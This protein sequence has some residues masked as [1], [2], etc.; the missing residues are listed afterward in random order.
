M[1]LNGNF[2]YT[3]R[4]RVLHRLCPIPASYGPVF[5]AQH[6]FLL[7]SQWQSPEELE[8]YRAQQLN[9][10]VTHC[11]ENVPYYRSLFE[12]RGLKPKDFL[13]VADLGQLPLLS[14]ETVRDNVERLVATNI[15][16]RDREFCTTGGTTGAPLGLWIEKRAGSLRLAFDWRFYGWAGFRF[17][18][19]HAFLRGRSISRLPAG[20]CWKFDPYQNCLFFSSFNLNEANMTL[21]LRKMREFKP[22]VLHRYPSSLEV[23]ASFVLDNNL[24]TNEHGDLQ[25]IITGSETITS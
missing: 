3:I 7:R 25:A 15:P 11:Y 16:L 1:G 22:R 13:S 2:F 20:Q 6:E 21:Y 4:R 10:L 12:G 8:A 19:R 5:A 9:K 18:D 17:H 24:E 14:K 23:L